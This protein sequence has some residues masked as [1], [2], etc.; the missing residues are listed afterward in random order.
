MSVAA[1]PSRD[2][3]GPGDSCRIVVRAPNWV[4]DSVMALPCV[5]RLKDLLPG[6][7]ISVLAREAVA[8]VFCGL[9]WLEEIIRI[10]SGADS[11]RQPRAH[12]QLLRVL[13][14]RGFDLG[15]LL[16]NSFASALV[17]ALA[18]IPRRVGYSGDG[19]SVLLSDRVARPS[20]RARPGA[21]EALHQVDYY[22]RLAGSAFGAGTLP[23]GRPGWKVSEEERARA[24][25]LLAGEGIGEGEP[26]VGI[27]PGAARGPA[28]AWPTERFAAVCD[29]LAERQGG[30]FVLL[31]AGADAPAARRVAGKTAARTVDLAGKTSLRMLGAVAERCMMVVSNDSGAMHV[32]AATGTPVVGLFLSTDPERTG[33]RG[34]RHQVVRAVVACRPCMKGRCPGRDYE[35]LDAVTV[36][37]VV[38]ACERVLSRKPLSGQ[39]P[40]GPGPGGE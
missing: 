37:E 12:R 13:R 26:V 25:E 7:G 10:P 32:A 9:A 19:R 28:K 22:L 33:P 30:V 18:G 36:D 5:E 6:A 20:V 2:A 16:P 23:G 3:P 4:G 34:G 24:S 39:E 14:K 29:R 17:F 35:C 27:C 11:L 15:F 38:A 21:G 8:D 31:G 40:S 1:R